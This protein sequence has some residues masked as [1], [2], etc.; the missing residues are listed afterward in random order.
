ME[1]YLP[2]LRGKRLALVVNHTLVMDGVH[3]LDTLLSQGIHVSGILWLFV[4]EHGFRGDLD[5]GAEVESGT[6]PATGIRWM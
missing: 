1:R 3:L 4:P 5:T 2:M 6:D